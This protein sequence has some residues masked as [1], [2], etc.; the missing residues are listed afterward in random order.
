MARPSKPGTATAAETQLR[1]LLAGLPKQVQ[2][3][4]QAA[5]RALR[6]RL[7][8]AHELAYDYGTHVV[9]SY[10]ATDKGYQ[11]VIALS[12]RESGLSL[13]FQQGASLPDPSGLLEG[14][15]P[16]RHLPLSRPADLRRGAVEA[17]LRHA[18][19]SSAVPF[20]DGPVVLAVR[21]TAAGKRKQAAS[22]R[23]AAPPRRTGTPRVK[24]GAR[25]RVIGGTHAGKSGIVRDV[26]TSAS[27]NVTITVVQSNGARFKT[28]ARNVEIV[29]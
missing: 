9:L 28:L 3:D 8:G 10:G 18:V 16:S 17:L 12:A 27:G 4:L 13:T 1:E 26:N 19:A 7:A 2:A 20:G 24:D 5:R 22:R 29:R 15:G 25:C 21:P 14:R 11:A 23:A 6:S